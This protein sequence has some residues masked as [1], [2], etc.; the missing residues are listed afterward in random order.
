MFS[1]KLI[2][3]SLNAAARTYS[4]APKIS[5]VGVIGLGLMGHGIA[6]VSAAAGYEV[7]A[8]DNQAGLDA[9]M[10]RIEGSVNKVYAKQVH[11]EKISQDEADKKIADTMGRLSTTVDRSGLADC[12][13]I[14]EA[15]VED[16]D[17][18]NELYADLGNL[19]KP[20]TIL[21]S[22]T[23]S[24]P[25]HVMA[26]ASGR[27][28]KTVG[29]HFFNPVQ[30][31]GLVEV[32]RTDKTDQGVFDAC[33]EYGTNVGKVA[34]PCKDTPG[35]IVNRLLVP[36]LAQAMLMLDR[37]EAT[38]NDIDNAIR[39]GAGHPMGPIT[40]S[41]YVGLD[42]MLNILEGWVRDYPD[43]PAFVVPECLKERV[44]AGKLGRKSG[45]GFYKWDGDKRL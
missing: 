44:A 41:D 18:K 29:L 37:D 31:M 45:E 13:L 32:V 15:I 40:L 3:V 20:E 42:T 23:S 36:N 17:I 35:F 8:L 2:S 27:P 34:I 43:E 24:L 30:L 16:V 39:L 7:V 38:P 28:D 19:C 9:G 14:V 10:K 26:T 33:M 11:K 1:R 22:N 25:I 4:T 6:Q 12:D 21:A 5:K